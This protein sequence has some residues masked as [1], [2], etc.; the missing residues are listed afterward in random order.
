MP[1]ISNKNKNSIHININT[2]K[3]TKTKRKTSKKKVKQSHSII[4]VNTNYNP[5]GILNRSPTDYINPSQEHKQLLEENK[6]LNNYHRSHYLELLVKRENQLNPQLNEKKVM[7][8][9]LPFA[10]KISHEDELYDIYKNDYNNNFDY[11]N[12]K[13]I[14]EDQEKNANVSNIFK[15]SQNQEQLQS[16]ESLLNTIKSRK[17]RSDKGMPRGDYTKKYID[18][19]KKK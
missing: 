9:E 13:P 16:G 5:S 12:D 15:Q 7:Q 17:E 19:T 18:N 1:K 2:E 11:E 4:Y 3:K 10:Q 8:T 14:W 6:V